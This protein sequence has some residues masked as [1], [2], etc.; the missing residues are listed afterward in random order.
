MNTQ[1]LGQVAVVFGATGGLGTA[2]TEALLMEGMQVVAVGRNEQRL[3]QLTHGLGH[4]IAYQLADINEQVQI[5]AAFE[6]VI[7]TYGAIDYVINAVGFDVRKPLVAH[8]E[9]DIDRSLNI[10]LRGAIMITQAFIQAHDDRKQATILHLGGFGDGRLAFPF[11]SVN[12]ASRA[13]LR[14][15]IESVNRELHIQARP[16]NIMYFGSAVADTEAERP[17]HAIWQEM[18]ITVESADTVAHHVVQA[19]SQNN[20]T[21]VM[22][23]GTNLINIINALSPKLADCLAMEQMSRIL[24]THFSQTQANKS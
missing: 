3:Q 10:N 9:A 24:R 7:Q 22:G 5:Q 17:F 13:G 12:V 2:I 21:Y 4:N 6:Q 23:V 15:F 20:M 14:A 1:D 11:Y 8:N 18:G 16:I 19:L